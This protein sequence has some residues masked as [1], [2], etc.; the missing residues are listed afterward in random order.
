MICF[1]DMT[2]C[3][4]DCTNTTCRRHYGPD[5]EAEAVSWWGSDRA[6]VAFSDFSKSCPDYAPPA[7]EAD[8]D[9]A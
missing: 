1:R 8:D 6:P 7:K 5:D 4:S 2:F 3:G 9:C